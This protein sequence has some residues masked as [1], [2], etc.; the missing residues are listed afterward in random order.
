[1]SRPKDS[2]YNVYLLFGGVERAEIVGVGVGVC[3]CFVLFVRLV[4]FCCCWWWWFCF[5]FV[6]PKIVF[7]VFAIRFS[8]PNK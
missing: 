2:I 8:W 5:G 3:F 4:G 6:L 1:M 7:T